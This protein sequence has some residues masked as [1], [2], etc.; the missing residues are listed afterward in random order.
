[1]RVRKGILVDTFDLNV[2]HKVRK[3]VLVDPFDFSIVRIKC[4]GGFSFPL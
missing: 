4:S 3:Y 1:M 2:E